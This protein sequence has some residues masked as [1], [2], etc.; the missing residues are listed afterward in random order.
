MAQKPEDIRTVVLAG[1]GGAGKTTLAE[2][3][4]FDAGVTTRLGKVEDG[5]TVLDFGPEEQK[6]QI[7]I[8]AALAT[9]PHKGKTLYLLDSPGYADFTGEM[10]SCMYVADGA[11]L[12]ASA[13]HG[14][15]VQTEKAWEFA[16]ENHLPVAFYLSKMGRENADFFLRRRTSP[17]ATV[18]KAARK[19]P[20]PPTCRKRQRPPGTPSWS[21][22][23]RRMTNS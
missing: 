11:V 12:V 8:N 6:R 18:A 4:L 21:A 9:V 17:R 20:F 2:A 10:R 13:V 15:E 3:V 5:N 23:W 14:V 16:A 19:A 1:H 22:S 7:S